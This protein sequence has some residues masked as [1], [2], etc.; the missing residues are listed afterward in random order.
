MHTLKKAFVSFFAI[1]LIGACALVFAGC[2]NSNQ[3]ASDGAD[4][5]FEAEEIQVSK[6]GYTITDDGT[7]RYAFVAVNPN[8]G[9]LAKDV[10][11]TIEGYDGD[12]NMIVGGGETL[13][14][15]YPG[16]EVAAAGTLDIF[17]TT[18]EAPK[19]STL[20]IKPMMDSVNWE[21]TTLTGTGIEENYNIEKARMA[22]QSDTGTLNITANVSIKNDQGDN[23]DNANSD[24]QVLEK[25]YAVALLE[26]EEGNLLCGSTPQTFEIDPAN[27]PYLFETEIPNAP[28]YADANLYVTPC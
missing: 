14:K 4:Q 8:N 23:A 16:S 5:G 9:H 1:A 2:S 25:A 11:F 22:T 19:L 15:M 18:S 20:T 12:G 17:E 7:V 24:L 26:D 10:V 27:Q 3:G 21:E 28:K 13:S 6:S